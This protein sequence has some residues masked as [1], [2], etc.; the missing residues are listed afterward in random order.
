MGDNGKNRDLSSFLEDMVSDRE[1]MGA[2]LMK[3][4][5]NSKKKKKKK[6]R[7]TSIGKASSIKIGSWNIRGFNHPLKQNGVK[8][9]LKKYCVDIFGVLECKLDDVKLQRI[10]DTK[11]VE[12][13]Q[14]NK[15]CT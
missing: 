14:C 7:H 11:F 5:K 1:E 15:K 4:K 12:W 3:W 6:G 8:E 10:M 2:T 9:M 13:S